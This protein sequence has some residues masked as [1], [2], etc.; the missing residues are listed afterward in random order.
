MTEE[1]ALEDMKKDAAELLLLKEGWVATH[2][3]EPDGFLSVHFYRD[4]DRLVGKAYLRPDRDTLLEVLAWG[5]YGFS[6]DYLMFSMESYIT[7]VMENPV[8]GKPWESGEM[9]VVANE[10]PE[11]VESGAVLDCFTICAF[12]RESSLFTEMHPFNAKNGQITW[13]EGDRAFSTKSKEE[14]Q[15]FGGLI[16]DF[17]KKTMK[18]K[19]KVFDEL[20]EIAGT[21]LE[22]KTREIVLVAQDFAAATR[23]LQID[24]VAG[25]MIAAYP[26]TPA[27][28]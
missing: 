7:N 8:T 17:V 24:M 10:Y 16:T 2:P 1:Q 6:A 13:L 3:D 27:L 15:Q 26:D 28:K 9:A 5:A 21:E 14:A 25:A 19:G 12:S 22:G 18:Q 23:L 11:H 4:D 20:Q